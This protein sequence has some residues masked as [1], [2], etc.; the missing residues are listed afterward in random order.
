MNIVQII[1]TIKEVSLQH[2]LV[3]SAYD[4]DV[5]ENWNSAETN[6]P[7][8]N[9]GIENVTN[10]GYGSNISVILYYGDRLLQDK[11]N[12]NEVITDG[13][14]TLQS[15]INNLNEVGNT[16]IEGDII[17]TPF[18]QKFSDYLAGVYARVTIETDDLLGICSMDEMDDEDEDLEN[19]K[20]TTLE[21]LNEYQ[22]QDEVLVSLLNKL[23]EFLNK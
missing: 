2:K 17:Y 22:T 3:N 16:N 14:N 6:Y 7:S 9:V 1:Q 13:V 23:L 21:K 18:V 10:G 19:L 20:E 4:G 12:S 15:I 8:V 11:S 5:Y